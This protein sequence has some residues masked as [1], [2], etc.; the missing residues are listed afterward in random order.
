MCR[1]INLGFAPGLV[2]ATLLASGCDRPATP[3]APKPSFSDGAGPC[4][5][6]ERFTGGGRTDSPDNPA[7]GKTTFGFNLDARDFCASGGP[8]TGQLQTKNHASQTLIHSLTIDPNQ[9]FFS[10]EDD[11]G[12][13]VFFAGMARVKEGNASWVQERY[14]AVACDNGEPGSRP[15][16]GPDRYG[17]ELLDEGRGTGVTLLTG[18]NI[19]AH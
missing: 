12:R 19:Q 10:F 11:R 6:G 9:G 8:I 3:A 15:G 16:G 5:G 17:I 1:Q 4:A 7:I 18:G 14:G 2:V 13:C